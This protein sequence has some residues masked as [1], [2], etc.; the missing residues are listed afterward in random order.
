MRVYQILIYISIF[1]SCGGEECLNKDIITRPSDDDVTIQLDYNQSQE[2]LIKNIEAL[3]HEDICWK[4]KTVGLE[5]NDRNLKIIFL[6]TCPDG[7]IRDRAVSEVKILMNGKGS[8]LLNS[9]FI[10]IDSIGEW[11]ANNF[12]NEYDYEIEEILFLWHKNSPKNEIEVVFNQI[13]KG[14]LKSYDK[15][16]N[17]KFNKSLCN[18]NPNE[19]RELEETLDFRIKLGFGEI[20]IPPPPPPRGNEFDLQ[21]EDL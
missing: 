19:I 16:S 18:L 2:E 6:K 20:V 15:I 10:E 3:F 7:I 1:Y 9:E 17:K 8:T 4:E 14:Y 12:P 5:L 21:N 13:R 11:I